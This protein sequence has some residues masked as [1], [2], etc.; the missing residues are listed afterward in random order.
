VPLPIEKREDRKKLGDADTVMVRV[1][2]LEEELAHLK[3]SYEQYFLGVER[4]PP[5][6]AHDKFKKGLKELKS[7]F[8]RHTGANFRVQGL[9]AKYLT[10]ERLWQRTLQEMEAGTYRRDVYKAKRK[11]NELEALKKKKKAAGNGL[12]NPDATPPEEDPLGAHPEDAPGAAAKP[13]LP[14]ALPPGPRPPPPPMEEDLL[15]GP[16]KPPPGASPSKTGLPAVAALKPV[17]GPAAAV[18]R[19]GQPPGRPTITAARGESP[20]MPVAR[21]AAPASNDGDLSEKKVKAIYDA[22]VMAK[23]RCN[24]DVS[25]LSVDTLGA[26]LRKQVPELMKQHGAKS[27]EFKVVIKDGKAILRA[28]PK[29]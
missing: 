2:E 20:S 28:L 21:G 9:Q 11:G 3:A 19:P 25:K 14:G 7:T 6:D 23:K 12:P 15:D 13:P 5:T 16:L 29:T 1:G 17:T 27:V 10:Y 24:E 22:Y 18:G 8:V 4:R 26:T